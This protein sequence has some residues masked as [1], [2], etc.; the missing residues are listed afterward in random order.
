MFTKSDLAFLPDFYARYILEVPQHDLHEA[1]SA[2][3]LQFERMDWPLLEKIGDM[4]YAPGK[5]TVKELLRHLIDNEWIQTYRA[6]RFS[7]GDTMELPGYDEDTYVPASNAAA[8]SVQ[9]LREEFILLRKASILLFKGFDASMVQRRGICF[10]KEVTVLALGFMLAGH[11]HH[12]LMVLR[13]RYYP[14]A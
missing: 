12:H 10:E 5:W 4:A 8:I 3:L 1:L 9:D 6:L 13:E 14:L 2:N 7:R 11:A